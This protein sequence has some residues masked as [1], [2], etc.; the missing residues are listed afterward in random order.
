MLQ[1]REDGS[2]GS[3]N[4]M[5]I[6]GNICTVEI[7]GTARQATEAIAKKLTVYLKAYAECLC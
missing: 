1:I 5:C 4:D 3:Q 6:P 7:L 2:F